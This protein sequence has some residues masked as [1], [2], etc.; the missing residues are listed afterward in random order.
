MIHGVAVGISEPGLTVVCG[1]MFSGK[2]ESLLDA[3]LQAD[4]AGAT[5]VLVK[6]RRDT[7]SG[8]GRV[9]TH[10]GRAAPALEA[11]AATD[12]REAAAAGEVV[13]VDEAHFFPP[14]LADVLV[15]LRDDGRHVVAAGLD[16][17]FRAEEF[18][19]VARLRVVADDT[20]VLT[21][22]C[23]RCGKPASLSQRFVDGEPAPLTDALLVPGGSE[24]YS[25]RCERC[26]WNERQAEHAPREL[27]P[28]DGLGLSV[29]GDG[30]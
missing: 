4:L 14:D 26:F 6:P 21:A 29:H 28:I 9:V 17:D 24:L 11:D 25:P 27:R 8:R 2:T 15:A 23:G 30:A 10:S 1:P 16:R 18:E 22:T 20:R 19:T 3:E 12:V 7:R 13:L 5:Y